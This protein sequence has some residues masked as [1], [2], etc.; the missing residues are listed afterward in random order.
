MQSLY[1]WIQTQMKTLSRHWICKS[2]RI[3]AETVG[4]PE[5]VLQQWLGGNRQ[6]HR[7]ERLTGSGRRPAGKTGSSRV[8]TA[9]AT[10]AVL[11]LLIGT[12]RLN[13]V[14]PEKWLRYVISIS[15]TGRQT[16][17]AIRCPG[18]LI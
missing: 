7:R 10:C 6:Q 12:C 1:D 8:P 5:R 11:Y 16:G 9:V 18:K 13:N 4:W 2:V 3:P 14:E 17:Y 15:R